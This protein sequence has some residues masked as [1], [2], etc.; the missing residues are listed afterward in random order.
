MNVVQDGAFYGRPYSYFGQHVDER[1]QPPRPD[2]VATARVPDFGL[3]ALDA[4]CKVVHKLSDAGRKSG[5]LA[6]RLDTEIDL[7][8]MKV[9]GDGAGLTDA[10]ET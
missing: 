8:A 5:T 4:Q 6:R 7:N 9:V 1:V 10:G 2:L 3:G